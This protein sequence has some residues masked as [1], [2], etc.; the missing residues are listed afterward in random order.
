MRVLYGLT[1]FLSAFLLFQVQPLIGRYIL[2]WFGSTPGVWTSC[3]VFF[4]L[5]LL[6]GYL[7]AHLITTFLKRNSQIRL[8]VV[9]LLISLLFLP[10]IPSQEWK[11]TSDLDPAFRILLLLTATV[12]FPYLLL[13]STA[14][15][16]QRWFADQNTATSPYRLYAISNAGSLLALITYPLLF[17][18]F[19]RLRNQV[20]SWS[21]GFIGFVI[22]LA[23]IA[24]YY[25]R[26]R[27]SAALTNRIPSIPPETKGGGS[28][29]RPDW[30]RIALWFSLSATG[31]LILVAT[32]NRI[33]LDVS[34]VPLPFII[35]LGLYLITFIIAFDSPRW[36]F[37]PVFILLLITGIGAA[38]IE[39]YFAEKLPLG[40]RIIIYS[41]TLFGCCSCCHGELARVK[42]LPQYL[43][44]F[45]LTMAMG[46]AFGGIFVALAAPHIFNRLWEFEIGLLISFA[47][48]MF[49]V[50]RDL[51]RK[52]STAIYE[53]VREKENSPDEKI[54]VPL[55]GGVAA[56]LAITAVFVLVGV[57]G[58]HIFIE[59]ENLVARE[60]SFYG[61]A[62]VREQDLGNPNAH[63]RVLFHGT[64]LHG[65]QL[66]QPALSTAKTSYFLPESGIGLAIRFHPKRRVPGYPFHIGGVG[67]GTGTI[68]A[69]ANDP[70]T[71]SALS[72]SIHFYEIDPM[73]VRFAHEYFTCLKEAKQRGAV[74]TISVGDARIEMERE[75]QKGDVNPYDV[76][77]IDA[78]SGDSVPT[79]L[80][81]RECYR[82]YLQLLKPDGILAFHITT[83]YLDLLPI[84]KA[85]AAENDQQIHVVDQVI[86]NR[87][88][89]G[90]RWILVTNNETFTNNP[91]LLSRQS[92]VGDQPG[93]LWTDDFSNLL[94]VIR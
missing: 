52:S 81:T 20:W 4:Q 80:L 24:L 26:I 75:I 8:H 62:S 30:K 42:P 94:D 33:S 65:T 17:E 18:R 28:I 51:F 84:I 70:D 85:L 7:Y 72:D 66:L 78:F 39:L 3:L 45:Y 48:I 11:V 74:V 25:S 46:G 2:P 21:V 6:C 91:E 10:I 88:V 31:S 54:Q 53:E 56:I 87:G 73:I 71:H 59:Q 60:R 22:L 43:T 58:V 90:S 1:S 63:C 61:V 38:C 5:L 68:A 89:L 79:H 77:A 55:V 47:L 82:T 14:P 16:L 9:L 13:S 41:L 29:I 93:I 32:T 40:F 36:Y 76:L 83:Y 50:I 92:P 64:I 27:Q 35:P 15:L 69:Y 49:L 23:L 44:L 12:G 19:L 67:L 37:R 86:E 57:F 34:P